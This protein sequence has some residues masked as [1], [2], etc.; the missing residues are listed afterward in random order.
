MLPAPAEADFLPVTARPNKHQNFEIEK[1][2]SL[3]RRGPFFAFWLEQHV[4]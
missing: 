4:D 3:R 1:P 2:A